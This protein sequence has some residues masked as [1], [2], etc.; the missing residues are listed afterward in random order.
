MRLCHD[1]GSQDDSLFRVIDKKS[2]AKKYGGLARGYMPLYG[3]ARI[4][5]YHLLSNISTSMLYLQKP[6]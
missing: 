5:T 4:K 2:K 3:S 6:T 1:P